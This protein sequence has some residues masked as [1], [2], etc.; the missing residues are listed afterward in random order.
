[1]VIRRRRRRLDS[2]NWLIQ[3]GLSQKDD[4]SMRF[5]EFDWI[6]R[7]RRGGVGNSSLIWPRINQ[8]P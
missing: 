8:R 1:M 3:I 5:E 4:D 6:I 7:R 2:P